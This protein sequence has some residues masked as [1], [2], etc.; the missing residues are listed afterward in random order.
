MTAKLFE[1]QS[2]LS[3]GLDT[4]K[5]PELLAYKTED[6]YSVTSEAVRTKKKWL[7]CYVVYATMLW[8]MIGSAIYYL[9]QSKATEV[10]KDKSSCCR[11]WKIANAINYNGPQI[12]WSHCIE[13]G[14]SCNL[15]N[16]QFDTFLSMNATESD[17]ITCSDLSQL[18]IPST[19][20][21]VYPSTPIRDKG[22]YR[23]LSTSSLYILSKDY[24]KY[25]EYY[26]CSDVCVKC[27]S[28]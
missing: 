22:C 12:G 15:C 2:T 26:F 6:L 17:D 18:N 28:C 4:T 10:K 24:H 11:C 19:Q 16:D 25:G 9:N 13:D 5:E 7:L 14:C 21:S 3:L 20:K 8:I 27:V 1:W 23:H